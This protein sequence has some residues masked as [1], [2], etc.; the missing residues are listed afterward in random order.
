[1]GNKFL[2]G[3]GNKTVSDAEHQKKKFLC[4]N[5]HVLFCLQ[6]S[7]GNGREKH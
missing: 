1:M 4:E 6:K 7:D 3:K 2:K 5:W